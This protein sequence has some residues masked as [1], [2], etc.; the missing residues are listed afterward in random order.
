[1]YGHDAKI[2][3]TMA[4]RFTIILGIETFKNRTRSDSSYLISPNEDETVVHGCHCRSDM[5]VRMR[6]VL[7]I[8]RSFTGENCLIGRR[9][10]T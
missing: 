4:K 7:A 2:L 8:L 1:M 5:V 3:P 9:A 10:T 6:K